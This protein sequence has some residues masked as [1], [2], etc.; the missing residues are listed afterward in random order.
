M[1]A[2]VNTINSILWSNFL[3]Y[4]LLLV[5][6]Y[7][8][9]KLKFVQFRLIKDMIAL[10]MD[11]TAGEQGITSFQALAISIAGRVGVGNIAGVAAAISLGG[12]G[13][14][15]WMWC[16]ALIG[17]ATAFVE[18]TLAQVYK[19][20][21]NG[22]YRGGTAYYIEKFTGLKFLGILFAISLIYSA[23]VGVPWLQSN[24]IATSVEGAFGISKVVTGITV[25]LLVGSVILGGVKRIGR[26]AEVLVPIMATLYIVVALFIIIFNIGE[27]LAVL[28]LI[29]KS[30]FGTQQAFA[31]IVGAAISNGVKRGIYSNEAGMGTAT[32][33]AAAADVSHPAKQGLVQAFSVYIDTML[34]CTATAFIILI[35]KSYNVMGS[36]GSFIVQHLPGVEAGPV[37][38][39]MAVDSIIPG[40]GS[41]F[42]SIALFLF[43][44]TT[45][46]AYYYAGE[47]VT[48]YIQEKTGIN[49]IPVLRILFIC[50]TFI[51]ATKTSAIAWGMADL[52]V[53]LL[54]WINIIAL[55]IS[56]GVAVKALKDYETQK[57]QGID[58]VFNATA[59]GIKNAD[60]WSKGSPSNKVA[61]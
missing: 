16:L 22:Q 39:Q 55:A 48:V 21:Y 51:G 60:V 5:G 6:V 32:Q 18:C 40:F 33:V 15:F 14:V 11:R 7:F 30:A 34:V 27:L 43:A 20:E 57:A 31:G 10:L 38:T 36:D 37:F 61:G 52:G 49:L 54:T 3:I 13:A 17:A 56:G 53:G 41:A 50:F 44:F 1:M 42:V 9:F 35:T 2:I 28:T 4:A 29:F 59:L 12:P 24:A 25:T 8:S 47:T 19:E 26:V 46:I 58:P 23:G 45:L